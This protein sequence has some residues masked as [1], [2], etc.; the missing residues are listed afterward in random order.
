MWGKG[1]A[2]TLADFLLRGDDFFLVIF[3]LRI[4]VPIFFNIVEDF[5]LER[6]LF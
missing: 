6:F 2:H 5:F 1:G 3:V 4:L